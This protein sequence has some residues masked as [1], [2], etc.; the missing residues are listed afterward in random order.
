[1]LVAVW[2]SLTSLLCLAHCVNAWLLTRSLLHHCLLSLN[3][4]HMVYIEQC[5]Q[6]CFCSVVVILLE[7]PHIPHIQMLVI[8]L[9][10]TYP[11]GESREGGSLE[12]EPCAH[13]VVGWILWMLRWGGHLESTVG[14]P[15]LWCPGTHRVMLLGR[16]TVLVRCVSYLR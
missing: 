12:H 10:P 8:S 14:F 7:C 3:H 16:P 9:L 11:S 5:L 15:E 13:F 4:Q 2:T 1:M 6:H